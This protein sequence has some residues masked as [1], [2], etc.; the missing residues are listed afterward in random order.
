MSCYSCVGHYVISTILP[1]SDEKTVVFSPVMTGGCHLGQTVP[2][3][4]TEKSV[5][6]LALLHRLSRGIVL[7]VRSYLVHCGGMMSVFHVF[8]W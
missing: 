8:V 6:G 4:E 1:P 2:R 7:V 5:G 3:V